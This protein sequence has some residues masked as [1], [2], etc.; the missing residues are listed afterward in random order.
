VDRNLLDR[1]QTDKN[2]GV[3]TGAFWLLERCHL[4]TGDDLATLGR[5]SDARSEWETITKGLSGPV[6]IYEPK[7]LL[8]LEAAD[9]RLGRTASAAVIAKRLRDM[10]RQPV[11]G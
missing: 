6:E 8:I 4:Q 2:A 11:G 7:L 3:N 9:V 5:L 10:S 1:L